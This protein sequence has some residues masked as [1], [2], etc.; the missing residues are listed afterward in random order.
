[1]SRALVW[2]TTTGLALVLLATPAAL[3]TP[4][5]AGP[6]PQP[7]R[8]CYG[9]AGGKP[10]CAPTPAPSSPGPTTAPPTVAP[11][12]APPTLPAPTGAAPGVPGAVPGTTGGSPRLDPAGQDTPTD[13]VPAAP[14]AGTSAEPSLD[15]PPQPAGATP[16]NRRGLPV[17]PLL[18]AA[19]GACV[20]M[21][22]GLLLERRGRPRPVPATPVPA[23]T[24]GPPTGPVGHDEPVPVPPGPVTLEWTQL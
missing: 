16:A 3:A 8:H 20:L 24:P 17:W 21:A 12:S 13:A 23:A 19:A 4:A 7:S 1:M 2:R 11:T 18:G 14:A 5:S 9:T 6:A 10:T 15:V 22:A